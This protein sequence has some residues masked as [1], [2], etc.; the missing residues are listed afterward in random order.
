M[1]QFKQELEGWLRLLLQCAVKYHGFSFDHRFFPLS[2]LLLI[3]GNF[4]MRYK[5]DF[6]NSFGVCSNTKSPDVILGKLLCI[7][8]SNTSQPR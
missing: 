6:I 2:I 7:H 4:L 5:L 3:D 1:E 8:C